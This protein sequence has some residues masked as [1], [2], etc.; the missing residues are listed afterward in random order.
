MR[1][2]A[3]LAWNDGVLPTKGAWKHLAEELGVS[4][5]ALYREITRRAN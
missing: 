2:E 1:L 4:P 5:E 3:W